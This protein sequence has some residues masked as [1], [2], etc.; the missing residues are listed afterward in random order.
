MCRCV[1]VCRCVY[2]CESNVVKAKLDMCVYIYTYIGARKM[3][4]TYTV[5]KRIHIIN[6]HWFTLL[7][8]TNVATIYVYA[9]TRSRPRHLCQ[10]FVGCG[11]HVCPPI[12]FSDLLFCILLVPCLC[13]LF[14]F[15]LFIPL[16]I[17]LNNC[18]IMFGL[19]YLS[20]L[21]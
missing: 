4:A 5:Y 7:Q 2:V 20:N 12:L 6:F 10:M 16:I 18:Q 14:Q 17:F 15:A 21:F 13:I 1:C 3:G 19:L 8:C 11:G 9:A